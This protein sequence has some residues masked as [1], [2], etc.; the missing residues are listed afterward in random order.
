MKSI[1]WNAMKNIAVTEIDPSKL[2]D[3]RN[4]ETN[5][6][7][8]KTERIKNYI[9]QLNG[10]PYFYRHDIYTV[11]ESFPETDLTMNDLLEVS[12]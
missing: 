7:L 5:A 6:S 8:P 4:I 10:N 11:K 12:W 3:R 2:I 1:E 9:K